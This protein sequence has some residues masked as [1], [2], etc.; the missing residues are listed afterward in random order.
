LHRN[1]ATRDID[2]VRERQAAFGQSSL[3]CAPR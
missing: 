1:I 3:Q 2:E